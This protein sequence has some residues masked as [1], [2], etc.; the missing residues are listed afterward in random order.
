MKSKKMKEVV[1][2]DTSFISLDNSNVSTTLPT[3]SV[4]ISKN[5]NNYLNHRETPPRS[6]RRYDP[7]QIDL[8]DHSKPLFPNPVSNKSRKLQLDEPDH[9]SNSNFLSIKQETTTSV[10]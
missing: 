3:I 1:L 2:S 10:K 6:I 9:E 7:P 4:P 8:S 5:T